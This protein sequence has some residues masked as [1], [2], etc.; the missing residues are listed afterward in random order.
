MAQWA[1]LMEEAS[2]PELYILV[3]RFWPIHDQNYDEDLL[4]LFSV[5]YARA[6]S[7]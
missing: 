3:P 1:S 6:S 7:Y 5:H 2:N 4:N